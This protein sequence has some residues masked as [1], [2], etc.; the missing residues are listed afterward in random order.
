MLNN[1]MVKDIV[2]NLLYFYAG[3]FSSA[4]ALDDVKKN[5][6]FYQDANMVFFEGTY[7]RDGALV[8]VPENIYEKKPYI[9]RAISARREIDKDDSYYTVL[10]ALIR[11]IVFNLRTAPDEIMV[12]E[13]RVINTLPIVIVWRR[14][15]YRQV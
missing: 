10:A 15:G 6:E 11:N 2:T 9:T 13:Q 8:I 4:I 5:I 12:R 1:G 14:S 3:R 7:G